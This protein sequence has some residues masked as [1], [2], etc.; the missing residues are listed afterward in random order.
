MAL[1][2]HTETAY[3]A[4]L[5]RSGFDGAGILEVSRPAD[6]GGVDADV[7]AFGVSFCIGEDCSASVKSCFKSGASSAGDAAAAESL[8]GVCRGLPARQHLG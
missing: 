2:G 6:P 5:P 4:C 7:P 3:I 1:H 8:L